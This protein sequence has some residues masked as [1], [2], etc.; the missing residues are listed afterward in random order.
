MSVPLIYL[1]SGHVRAHT[2]TTT[3]TW[4]TTFVAPACG[5]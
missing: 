5:I 3:E 1:E 2:L 4:N